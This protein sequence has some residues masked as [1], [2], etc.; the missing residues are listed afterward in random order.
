MYTALTVTILRFIGGTYTFHLI[1]TPGQC[2][3][4]TTAMLNVNVQV[5]VGKTLTER[6]VLVARYEGTYFR[7]K[8]ASGLVPLFLFGSP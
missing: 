6:Y 7:K 8:E 2:G 3:S 4:T 1:E 5:K